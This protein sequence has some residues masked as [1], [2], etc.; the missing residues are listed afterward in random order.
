M[1]APAGQISLRI[2]G[3]QVMKSDA[4]DRLPFE[5]RACIQLLKVP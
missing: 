3:H 5:V 1:F 4:V 2:D